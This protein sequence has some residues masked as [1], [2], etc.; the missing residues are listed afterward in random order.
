MHTISRLDHSETLT[1]GQSTGVEEFLETLREEQANF[2]ASV[3]QASSR[4]G[5]ESGQ[6]AHVAAIHSRLTQQFFDAQRQIMTR[7]AEFD[8]EVAHIGRCAVSATTCDRVD[9]DL[10]LARPEVAALGVAVVRTKAEADALECVID[11][12]FL[13]GEPDG[14]ESQ[15]QLAVVL[16]QWWAA[17]NREGQAVIDL[18]RA[19]AEMRGHVARIEAGETV[20]TTNDK[21][22]H[23]PHGVSDLLDEADFVDLST[24][25]EKLAESLQPSPTDLESPLDPC[26]ERHG[27]R[28]AWL[29][30]DVPSNEVEQS[31]TTH[32][33]WTEP[34]TIAAAK[35]TGRWARGSAADAARPGRHD[36]R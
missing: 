29:V 20:V 19:R 15:Q 12:A 18:A 4:L 3:R 2:L 24:L 6:L 31:D 5:R 34:S 26:S 11:D 35:R 16:D 32:D 25:L 8:Q 33:F 14:T 30:I 7:R 36:R 1:D 28:R 17:E 22:Q 27:E 13:P 9:L 23:L 10:P 21:P